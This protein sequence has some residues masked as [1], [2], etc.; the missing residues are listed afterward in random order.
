MVTK[1]FLVSKIDRPLA[2]AI[3]GIV[4]TLSAFALYMRFHV[5]GDFVSAAVAPAHEQGQ[6]IAA[7]ELA[8]RIAERVSRVV[9]ID[10]RSAEEFAVSHIPGALSLGGDRSTKSFARLGDSV[11]GK[12]LVIV[13]ARGDVSAKLADAVNKGPVDLIGVTITSLTG[14]VIGWANDRRWLHD[15][16]GR[17]TSAIHPGGE[18]NLALVERKETVRFTAAGLTPR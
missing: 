18:R 13:C 16:S 2:G 3:T 4:A 7:G 12:T 1:M 14:G 8:R 10:I 17:V 11:R 9:V 5:A 15:N 6:S